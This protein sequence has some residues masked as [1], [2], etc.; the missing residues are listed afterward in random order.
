MRAIPS[1]RDTRLVTPLNRSIS[2]VS[3]HRRDGDPAVVGPGTIRSGFPVAA[4]TSSAIRA[5]S[6]GSSS[7]PAS[8]VP[9]ASSATCPTSPSTR[10]ARSGQARRP[11]RPSWPSRPCRPTRPIISPRCHAARPDR[12][13]SHSSS[14]ARAGGGAAAAARTRPLHADDRVRRAAG[15]RGARC[16]AGTCIDVALPAGRR[17]WRTGLP[18]WCPWARPICCGQ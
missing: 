10:L 7:R 12:T 8:S 5:R 9:T 18:W 1:S 13:A 16:T 15:R 4:A 11:S 6:M 14:P 3:G 17:T 2:E